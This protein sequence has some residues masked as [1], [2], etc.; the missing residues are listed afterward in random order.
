MPLNTFIKPANQP[1]IKSIYQSISPSL[2]EVVMKSSWP[3]KT[4]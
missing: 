2:Y 4:F 1:I 3:N